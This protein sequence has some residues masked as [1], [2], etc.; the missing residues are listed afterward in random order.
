MRAASIPMPADGTILELGNG[1][2]AVWHAG[3]LRPVVRGGDFPAQAATAPAVEAGRPQPQ[4]TI[5]PPGGP[6]VRHAQPG[7]RQ[8]YQTSGAAFGATVTQPLVAVPGY[9]AR[10]R[11]Q[12]AA[13]GGV[14][15]GPVVA[16]AADAPYSA[17]SLVT[18]RDAFGTPLIVGPGYE[19]LYLVPLVGGQWG[20]GPAANIANL[21][22]FSAV[23]TGGAGTGN[24]SFPTALPLEFAKG[25]GVISGA[26]ASLLPTII[27]NYAASGS[28]Y[29][30]A[31]GTLPTLGITLDTDF[32]WLP[33]ATD[34]EPVGLGSTLQWVLQQANPSIPS[35]ST[36]RVGLPRMGG[37]ITT[38][39][40]VLRDSTG[41]RIDQF[42]T[43]LRMYVDGVPLIDSTFTELQDDWYNIFGGVAR[44]TGVMAISR[45]T[46][47]SQI[48]HGLLDT[49]ETY[50]STN[51]GTLIEIEGAPWGT[52]A[53][54]PA[55]L[56]VIVGQVVPS[57]SLVQGLPEL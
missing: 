3:K 45:K 2:R 30:T 25:Y 27:W 37:F 7:R 56:N 35:A 48:S 32:Y 53:N 42:P 21:P 16:A 51:P 54:A 47:L 14:N 46:S 6:F 38:I 9:I 18:L 23:S 22:S 10:Y 20:I 41:A 4:T 5:E 12:I 17:V 39:I 34:I 43:R 49:G 29:T 13:S 40:L 55:T 1:H 36:T 15:G 52:I 19:M 44:P 26:N 24:F 57:G 28:V 50:L 8:Q 31:P 33:D 11:A